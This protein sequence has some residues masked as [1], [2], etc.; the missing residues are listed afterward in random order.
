[1][2]LLWHL[3]APGPPLVVWHLGFLP[4][5]LPRARKSPTDIANPSPRPPLAPGFFCEGNNH[6][7]ETELQVD[8]APFEVGRISLEN[9]RERQPPFANDLLCARPRAAAPWASPHL[10]LTAIITFVAQMEDRDPKG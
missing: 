6:E 1:M 7:E 8:S 2:V 9:N 4:H 10:V 3:Q 5:V